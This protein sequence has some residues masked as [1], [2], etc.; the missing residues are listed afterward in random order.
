LRYSPIYR[1][2]YVHLSRFAGEVGS[3]SEPG[4]GAAREAPIRR[5]G[6]ADMVA[7]IIA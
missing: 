3:R 4:E 5:A 1:A 6:E 2:S 7:P